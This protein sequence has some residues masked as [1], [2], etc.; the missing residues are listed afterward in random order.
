[1]REWA[2]NRPKIDYKEA[3][4]LY[5]SGLS[6]TQV[7]RR[8]GATAP[9]ILRALRKSGRST[10]SIS[11]AKI[12]RH[13][14]SRSKQT[15]GYVMVCMG[16]GTRRLE[17]HLVAEKALGRKL[18]RGEHVHHINCNPADNRPEN[19]LICS[20]AYHATLHWRMS[21]H[22]YWST[23]QKRRNTHVE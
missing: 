2:K 6:T 15:G 23:F 1:M 13:V 9:T 12:L 8:L 18:R 5:D 22:P 14:G 10:R 19:L 7:G 11:D 4:R 21:R 17:H 16:D 20:R 3:A